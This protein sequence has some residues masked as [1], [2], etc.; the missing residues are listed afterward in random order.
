MP[1]TQTPGCF[2]SS[3]QRSDGVTDGGFARRFGGSDGAEW[4]CLRCIGGQSSSYIYIYIYT[5]VC[6]SVYV[7]MYVCIYMSFMRWLCGTIRLQPPLTFLT[8]PKPRGINGRNEGAAGADTN[9]QIR[10]QIICYFLFRHK[11]SFLRHEGNF[12]AQGIFCVVVRQQQRPARPRCTLV[13]A[14]V[15]AYVHCH[16]CC[17]AR[18]LV[19]QVC[20]DI[21]VLITLIFPFWGAAYEAERVRTW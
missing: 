21:K 2:Y 3:T 11:G 13:Y 20:G 4:S 1:E 18:K 19:Q 7:C 6:M 12:L 5:Y 15:C 14:C 17:T 8:V 9:T 10:E 16:C